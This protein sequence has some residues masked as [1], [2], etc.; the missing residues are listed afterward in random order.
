M[1]TPSGIIL[2]AGRGSRMGGAT[3]NQTKC[4]TEISGKSLLQWQIE[5]FEAAGIN[6]IAVVTGYLSSTLQEFATKLGIK[7]FFMK[8][9]QKRWT[10]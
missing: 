5:S 6:D 7:K 3:S 10:D 2:A 9:F 1:N 4:M 8:P